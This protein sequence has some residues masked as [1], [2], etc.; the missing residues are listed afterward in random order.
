MLALLI[1]FFQVVPPQSP[2]TGNMR[3]GVLKESAGCILPFHARQ[4]PS[5]EAESA[6]PR[7]AS[8]RP[9]LTPASECIYNEIQMRL[10]L[11]RVNEAAP[12][13]SFLWKGLQTDLNL[14]QELF[15]ESGVRQ[16]GV[17]TGQG[18]EGEMLL[19]PA[20]ALWLPFLTDKGIGIRGFRI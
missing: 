4:C 6:W 8:L 18:W 15:L 9:L 20:Q 14:L 12:C 2:F 11:S 5:K 10:R 19:I 13:S 3:D 7:S 1:V 17:D 16:D